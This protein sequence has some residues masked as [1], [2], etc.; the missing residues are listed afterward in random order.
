MAYQEISSII[1]EEAMLCVDFRDV[2]QIA[3]GLGKRAR[4]VDH[5]WSEVRKVSSKEKFYHLFELKIDVAL[6]IRYS[7]PYESRILPGP[8][9]VT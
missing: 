5:I 9:L 8:S 4:N 2:S 1:L 6:S 3:L 7:T